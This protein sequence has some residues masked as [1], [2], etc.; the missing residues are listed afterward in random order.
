LLA[1][2]ASAAGQT[3]AKLEFSELEAMQREELLAMRCQY[4][5]EMSNPAYYT[6]TRPGVP[7]AGL[8]IAAR[9]AQEATR[10]DRILARKYG[11][12]AQGADE[13][14]REVSALCRK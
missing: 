14:Q 9:C 13:V 12:Q 11:I 5:R 7:A 8:G 2:S 6:S 3:C 1:V 10:M 4:Q